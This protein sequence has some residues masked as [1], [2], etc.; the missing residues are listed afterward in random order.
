[1]D[2][3]GRDA[4][5]QRAEDERA[6]TLA[7]QESG[8]PA[9][10]AASSDLDAPLRKLG[11]TKVGHR[12]RVL[13][14][15]RERALSSAASSAG[16]AEASGGSGSTSAIPRNLFT[17]WTDDSPPELV[18]CCV[19]LMRR[20]HPGWNVTTLR[21]GFAGLPAPP[22]DG[23]SGAQQA[24]WYRLHALAEHGGVYLDASCVTLAPCE[25]WVRMSEA[26][27]QGYEF[28][29][30]GETIESWAIACPRGS[31]L[32][33]RWRDEFAR[34]V[35]MGHD[36]R[37]LLGPYCASLPAGVVTRGLAGSLPYLAIHAAWRVARRAA[38]SERVV[39][40]SAVE[41][42][43]PYRYLAERKW[44][45]DEAVG[46]LFGKAA[47]ELADTPLIKLRG[48]ERGHV[49]GLGSYGRA[50]FLARELLGSTTPTTMSERL[51]FVSVGLELE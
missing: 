35:A 12:H 1:M 36:A 29:H 43:R 37:G 3:G 42:G 17:F 6:L 34:A 18:R 9:D 40:H 26:A 4:N 5:A 48:R 13:G 39:L 24:D 11:I 21:P 32:V 27:V 31:P 22:S 28:V 45:S 50:S 8:M 46:A 25:A 14:L 38:P 51:A 16:P 23:L 47:A 41:A 20:R 33:A 10:L 2:G 49:R 7:L 19:A 44:R 30:D 15:L